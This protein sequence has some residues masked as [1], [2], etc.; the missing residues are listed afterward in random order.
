MNGAEI[1]GIDDSLGEDEWDHMTQ[2]HA[3][4]ARTSACI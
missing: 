3:V 1:R 4:A 2:V